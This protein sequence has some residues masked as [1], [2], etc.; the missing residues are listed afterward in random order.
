MP[1][2]LQIFDAS[3]AVRVD[4]TNRLTKLMGS[5]AISAPGSLTLSTLQG[6]ALF[7]CFVPNSG[8]FGVHCQPVITIAGQTITWSY[9]GSINRAAGT[10]F[11]GQ[12]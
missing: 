12:Y 10:V 4:V 11:Y 1:Q 3:G 6:N 5:Q 9:P 7:A 2:G 8:A